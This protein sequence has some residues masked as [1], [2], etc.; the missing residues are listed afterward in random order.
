[1]QFFK[2][3]TK[4]DFMG[5]RQAFILMSLIVVLLSIVA[6]FV[7]GPKFGID[8]VGGTEIQVRFYDDSASVGVIRQTLDKLGFKGAEV[9]SFGKKES[10]YLLRLQSISPISE[11]LAASSKEAFNAQFKDADVKRFEFSPGGDKLAIRVSKELDI[12]TVE[13]VLTDA[14]LTLG[15]S[16]ENADTKE[17][18][19]AAK[20]ADEEDVAEGADVAEGVE[21]NKKCESATCTWPF[22]DLFAY[23]VSLKGISERVMETLRSEPFGK[24]AEMMRSEWVGPKVGAQLREAGIWSIIYALIFIMVYIAIRFDL[25]FAP[26]AVVALI[27]DI[28]ITVGV[29]TIA[30]VEITLATIAA[31]LT[32]VGYSL[33]D[34]I[35]VFDR[36]RENLSKMKERKLAAVINIS[37]NQTL[38]RTILTSLTTL[39]VVVSILTIGFRTTI[40]DFAFAL[41]VGVIV[42]T[43]SSIFIASPVVVWLDQRF[44]KKQA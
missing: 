8:F 10:E 35:V 20:P 36:I 34:T 42:G 27:H 13:K 23:E 1:M 18:A 30:R 6:T 40:R 25:R 9:V 28:L 4:Y 21:T 17:K 5:K 44:S 33:N 38:S 37:I 11:K 3:T 41:L 7:L 2:E 29:F 39:I 32:I 14:G 15:D 26:G 22:Q 12:A 16:L 43:Y 19:P 31:L 24:K